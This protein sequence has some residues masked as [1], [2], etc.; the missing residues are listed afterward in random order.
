MN[1]QTIKWLAVAA[2]VL[3]TLMFIVERSNRSDTV[4]GGELLLPEL[5]DKLNDVNKLVVTGDGDAVT[6]QRDG[7]DWSVLEK[8]GFAADTG[9]LRETLLALADARK[10]EQKT[11]NPDRL[12]QLGLDGPDAGNGR[13]VDLFGE[14]F[15][16]SLIIGDEAQ[17]TNRY[18]R[19]ADDGP[20]GK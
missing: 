8:S 13:R 16:Y 11:S 20:S 17:S 5:K 19:M 6:I 10:L 18:V 2:V 4:A 3:L 15:G 9:K 7:D 1:S 14:D 12:G